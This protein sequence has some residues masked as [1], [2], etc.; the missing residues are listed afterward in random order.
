MDHNLDMD[1][2]LEILYGGDATAERLR[3]RSWE[4]NSDAERT[5]SEIIADVRIKGD[6]AVREYTR[7]FDGVEP[8]SFIVPE[9]EIDEASARVHAE[10]P[11]L[12]DTFN[13]AAD[14]IRAYHTKQ[15]RQGFIATGERDG[16]LAGQRILPLDRVGLYIPGGTA[17]YPSTVFM[18]VIPARIAGVGE[19]YMAS[20]PQRDGKCDPA[21]LTA[22]RLAGVDGVFK[23]GGAQAIAAFAFGTESVPRVDKVTGPGNIYVATAKRQLYGI[24]DIEMIAGPS[25]ILIIADAG[26]DARYVAADML[27]QAEHDALAAALLLTTDAGLAAAVAREIPLQLA[28][29]PRRDIAAQSLRGHGRIAVVASLAQAA[30]LSN[31]IAPEHL[32]LCVRDPFALLGL[33]KHAGS[34][35]LGDYTPEAL[36]DYFA[37]P[38]HTL[39]T[40]GAA[41][42]ASPLSVDDFTKKS[43]YT[44]YSKEAL[45]KD[46]AHVAR[47]AR[48]ERF[49]AHARSA[50]IRFID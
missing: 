8:E 1:I 24:V 17:A 45:H 47:F 15:V 14:N 18:N 43:S 34:V 31:Q 32:E 42:F 49:E 25:E 19:V 33:I 29:L 26:A 48:Q 20:P 30:E 4:T 6:A 12:I 41:R 7:R 27:S 9:S 36:G 3:A 39:P 21:I 35:F 5:V 28:T 46:M 11:D 37:G 22:A 23:M 38:N 40:N 2:K 44:Y 16:V 50:E 10:K 13:R